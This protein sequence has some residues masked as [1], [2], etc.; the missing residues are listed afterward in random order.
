MKN[1]KGIILIVGLII[2]LVLTILA[3]SVINFSSG[4]EKLTSNQRDKAI[5]FQAAESA[6]TD[7]ETWIKQQV[8]PPQSASVCNPGPCNVFVLNTLTSYQTQPLSWWSTYGR[9]YSSTITQAKTQPRFIIEEYSFI[10]YDLSPQ[11]SSKRSGYYYY[12]ITAAGSGA[13]DNAK[14]VVQSIYSTQFN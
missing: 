6:L 3:I 7:G 1:Q 8:A 13:T 4:S 11:T 12:R 10:P 2:L 9:P 5:S 14:S